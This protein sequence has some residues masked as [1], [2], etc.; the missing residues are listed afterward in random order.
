MEYWLRLVGQDDGW[1]R[2]SDATIGAALD[3]NPTR[4]KQLQA[5]VRPVSQDREA[6]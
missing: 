5:G 2:F 1:G 3:L 6:A 4:T